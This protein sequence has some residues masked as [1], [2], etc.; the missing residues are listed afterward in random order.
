MICLDPM[1]IYK[2]IQQY[3]Q[4]QTLVFLLLSIT[5]LFVLSAYFY[6]LKSPWEKHTQARTTMSQLEKQLQHSVSYQKR[7]TDQ[8][9]AIKQ[10]KKQLSAIHYNSP[11]NQVTTSLIAQLDQLARQSEIEIVNVMPEK[12]SQILMFKERI[13]RI[14]IKGSYF[15][16]F[17]WIYLLEHA[18]SSIVIKQFEISNQHNKQKQVQ[19]LIALYQI[20][21]S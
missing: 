11:D 7:I 2:Q 10:L 9:D 1:K 4:P 8:Q 6:I 15:Q 14:E 12:T 17:N 19:L 21:E 20:N 13:Y 18:S 3:I 16:I 5:V